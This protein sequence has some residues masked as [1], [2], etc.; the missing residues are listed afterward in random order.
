MK[1][2]V[3]NQGLVSAILLLPIAVYL[4]RMFDR[5][6]G[7]F[8]AGNTRKRRLMTGALAL[9]SALPI[10]DFYSF[11]AMVLLHVTVIGILTDLVCRGLEKWNRNKRSPGHNLKTAS[12]KMT[13]V[14]IGVPLFLTGLVILYGYVNT[15]FIVRKEYQV[16]TTKNI[17]PGG[18]KILYLSDLHIGTTMDTDRLGRFCE[19]ME[20]ERPD[21]IILGGD[22]V[23]ESSSLEEVKETFSLFGNMESELGTYYIYGN[24]DK[25]IY[26]S[27]CEFSAEELKAAVEES[28][29]T[30]LEDD[31]VVL[32][33]ELTLSGRRDRTE[34]AKAG[35]S[36]QSAKKLLKDQ[37]DQAFHILADHQPRGFNQNEAAGFD[38]MLS[39]HTHG[40]QMWPVGLIT[41]LTDHET[42]NYGQEK[43]GNMDV[44]VSSG[45][46]G[47]RYPVRTGRHCE[48]VVVYVEKS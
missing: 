4:Y 43:R 1:H 42:I 34:A 15:Q 30:L 37:D 40:G 11:G 22:I 14:R 46:A 8:L 39:G 28:G 7:L 27:S 38:L 12:V 9:I 29:I 23:D 32:N 41:T 20:E 19:K 44:I 24:H 10:L 18:Y 35:V 48:Y 6:L 13:Y 36:R 45:M 31:T 26:S 17:R 2:S 21:L 33:Q 25:G 47:W 16:G 5:V 3:L